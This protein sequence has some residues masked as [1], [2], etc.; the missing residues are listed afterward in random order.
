VNSDIIILPEL[1]DS[2]AA[3]VRSFDEFLIVSRRWNVVFPHT[4]EFGPY[5]DQE[6]REFV[7]AH[8][9][10][11]TPYGIDLFV[12]SRGVCAALPPFALGSDSWDNYLIM[13]ARDRGIPVVDVTPSVMLVH[14]QHSLGQFRSHEERR[15]SPERRRNFV[16]MGDSYAKL[17]RTIDA[18]HQVID[19]CV[20]TS[21]TATI[22][23]VVPHCGNP[24]ALCHCLRTIEHQTYA[25]SY[26]DIIAVNND[27]DAPLRYL[28]AD[29]PTLRVINQPAPG[30]AAARNTGIALA[31]GDLVALFDSDTVPD[32]RCLEHAARLLLEQPECGIVVCRIVPVFKRGPSSY[33]QRAIEWFDAITH[34]NQQQWLSNL[35]AFVTAGLILRRS[36]FENYGYFDEL[37]PE[38]AS[39]DWEWST[40][41]LSAGAKAQFCPAAIV[42][43]PT[44]R[45]I[46]DLR[47]K[48]QRYARGAC[49]FA[50]IRRRGVYDVRAIIADEWHELIARARAAC[51]H[52][53]LPNRYRI[54]VLVAALCSAWWMLHE[55]LRYR[56][57]AARRV[58]RG[59]ATARGHKAS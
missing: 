40:R 46:G 7:R 48:K 34:Y 52:P 35:G 45:T 20:Q 12:F 22:T 9:E 42:G 19:G 15:R 14:Q 27:P 59:I 3:V 5:W 24:R 51:R 37:F 55:K 1:A 23:V 54:G 44:V 13:R 17:G 4:I 58:R 18:T 56:R 47:R 11:Y 50:N 57:R 29:F 49:I 10:L 41:V 8:G 53:R 33:V 6:V 31:T 38:A 2:I 32:L 30:P 28:E 16:W 36:V 26:I 25:R 21:T 43:H 39:E